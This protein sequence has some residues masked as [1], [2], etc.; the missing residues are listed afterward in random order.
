M[1]VLAASVLAL[2]TP[3]TMRTSIASHH[4]FTVASRRVVSGI[5]ATST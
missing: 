2:V 5:A 3:V 4:V 1:L